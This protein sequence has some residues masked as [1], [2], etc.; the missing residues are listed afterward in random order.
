MKKDRNTNTITQIPISRKDIY[1]YTW[2]TEFL[3]EKGFDADEQLHYML[4]G[5][6]P[7]VPSAIPAVI[8]DLRE[9]TL[10]ITNTTCMACWCASH[11]GRYPLTVAT[12]L[13]NYEALVERQDAALYDALLKESWREMYVVFTSFL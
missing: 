5:G 4:F 1:E 12:F 7:G 10:R 2:L 9:R 8:V 11:R 13:E 6:N 3:L